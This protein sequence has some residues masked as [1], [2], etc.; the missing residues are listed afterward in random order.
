[1]GGSPRRNRG[2]GAGVTGLHSFFIDFRFSDKCRGELARRGLEDETI[3]KIED[4]VS[5]LKGFHDSSPPS[6]REQCERLEL[7][8][9][10]FAQCSKALASTDGYTLSV[11]QAE[12][13]AGCR[14]G[15]R[16]LMEALVSYRDAAEKMADHTKPGRGPE[17][18]WDSVVV[19]IGRILR[20]SGL[21]VDAKSK[22]LFVI[23]TAIIF[24]EL[25]VHRTDARNEV[26]RALEVL[27]RAAS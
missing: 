8:R 11:L 25:G 23:S 13:F 14:V 24:E 26:R 7:L 17:V 6:R 16:D 9:E 21:R 2:R 10:A 15:L 27:E 18:R 5:Y 12:G 4:E 19:A 1:V 22:G 3:A 20:E